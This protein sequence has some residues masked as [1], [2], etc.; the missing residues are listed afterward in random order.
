MAAPLA[1]LSKMHQTSTD[2]GS[3]PTDAATASMNVWSYR[4][5]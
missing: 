4:D 5:Q 3:E 1:V 2:A